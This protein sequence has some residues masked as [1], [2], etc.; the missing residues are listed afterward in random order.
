[1]KLRVA[2]GDWLVQEIRGLLGSSNFILAVAAALY[3][4]LVTGWGLSN[5]QGQVGE[6]IRQWEQ[7]GDP[8]RAVMWM[9]FGNSL[10][11]MA[12]FMVPPLLAA[13]A[14]SR[15]YDRGDLLLYLSKPVTR[16]QFLQVKVV[17]SAAAF[18]AV[19]ALATVV[20][21]VRLLPYWEISVTQYLLGS[22]LVLQAGY[23]SIALCLLM[24]VLWRSSLGAG[25]SS[26]ALLLFVATPAT[27][28]FV[29]P[30]LRSA[31]RLSP[32][33]GATLI[34]E[35]GRLGAAQVVGA[36]LT[37]LLGSVLLVMVAWAVMLRQ[38]V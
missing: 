35:A 4:V 28:W 20:G 34:L 38:E 2:L 14:I 12:T 16:G 24:S 17:A 11:K 6:I 25:L 7:L 15:E 26:A 31:A 23:L 29:Q 36:T 32:F 21:Y 27:N 3:V 8:D 18:T 13:G 30:E 1:M 37:F 9:W 10:L 19:F 22:W 33:A 5:P